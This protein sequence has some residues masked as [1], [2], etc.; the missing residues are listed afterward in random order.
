MICALSLWGDY[1]SYDISEPGDFSN[2]DIAGI[3]GLN[4]AND[5]GTTTTTLLTFGGDGSGVYVRMKIAGLYGN[6][7]HAVARF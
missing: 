7:N 6:T 3:Y 2:V 5:E 1:P 4:Q